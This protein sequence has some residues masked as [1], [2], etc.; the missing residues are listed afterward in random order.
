LTVVAVMPGSWSMKALI[1]GQ[2]AYWQSLVG[3]TDGVPPGPI[4]CVFPGQVRVQG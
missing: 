2:P 1:G 3:L 4:Q